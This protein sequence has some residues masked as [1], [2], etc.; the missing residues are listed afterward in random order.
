MTQDKTVAEVMTT[1]LVTL[2]L[3]D[4]LRLADDLMNL[5][6]LR[7]F[8]V[9]D[10]AKVV[11]LVNQTDL[12]HAS[13]RSLA[14][15]PKNTLRHALGMVAVKDVMKPANTVSVRKHSRCRRAHGGERNRI[16]TRVG[17]RKAGR[18]CLTHRFAARAGPTING[19]AGKGGRHASR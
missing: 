6:K 13:M 12:L 8:P 4:T 10:D 19:S 15:H 9:L 17:R 14:H 11:G 1:D 7:H 18:A 3:N 2:K 16:S 5:A